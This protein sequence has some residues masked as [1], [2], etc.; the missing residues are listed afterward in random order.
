MFLNMVDF[1]KQSATETAAN[2][3]AK[4]LKAEAA[5]QKSAI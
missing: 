5:T 4:V 2:K 3:M 1:F